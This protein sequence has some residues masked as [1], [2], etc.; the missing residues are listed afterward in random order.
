MK[1]YLPR[2]T[3]IHAAQ[4]DIWAE[5]YTT[6]QPLIVDLDALLMALNMGGPQTTLYSSTAQDFIL[7]LVSNDHPHGI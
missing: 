3:K 5:D 1:E 4:Q 2:A 6:P 7:L